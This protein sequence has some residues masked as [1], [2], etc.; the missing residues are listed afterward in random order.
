MSHCLF[1]PSDL[2]ANSFFKIKTHHCSGFMLK[3]HAVVTLSKAAISLHLLKTVETLTICLRVEGKIWTTLPNFHSLNLERWF[4]FKINPTRMQLEMLSPTYPD[5]HQIHGCKLPININQHEYGRFVGVANPSQDQQ[6]E[7][8]IRQ[9]VRGV[10]LFVL[11]M[12]YCN[13]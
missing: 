13:Y 3:F 10:Q 9:R 5:A 4:I 6:E 7:T 11:K 8:W 12:I 2:K 1:T